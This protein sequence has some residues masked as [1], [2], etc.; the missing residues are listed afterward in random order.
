MSKDFLNKMEKESNKKLTEN[1]AIAYDTTMSSLLDAFSTLGA[2]RERSDQ[3]ILD[4]FYRAFAEDKKLAIKL[5]FYVRDIRGIGLGERRAFRVILSDLA[6]KY[7]HIIKDNIHNI[8]MYGRYDDLLCL[9]GTLAEKDALNFIDRQ[10]AED[11]MSQ[12]P[13]LL[14]KW[15]PSESSAN[16]NTR[17]NA[18]IIAK[19]I[20]LTPTAYRKT[21]SSLR[22]KIRIVETLLSQNRLDEVDF[23]ILPS[24]AS[25]RYKNT[26]IK[27][28]PERYMEYLIDLANGK[29]N[30]N[31]STLN[32]VD[33][34]KKILT[35]RKQD[36]YTSI[37]YDA[38]WNA[39]PNYFEGLDETGICVVDTSGSMMCNEGYPLY[40]AVSLGIYCADKCKGAF[41]NKFITFSDNPKIQTVKGHNI[42]EKVQNLHNSEWGMSTNI[43]K[44]FDLILDTA[45]KNNS[46]QEDIPNKLYLITDMEWNMAQRGNTDSATLMAIIE[47]KFK[48]AG[49]SMPQLVY[50]NVNARN[51][52]FHNTV[53]E[54]GY[55][56]VSG[57]SAGTFKAI[58]QGTELVEEVN[59]EGEVTV[60]EKLDPVLM[61]LNTL[62]NERYDAIVI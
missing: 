45:I 26:F 20:N 17:K 42:V 61:M 53:D 10:L 4:T 36:M 21:I 12:T 28:Q 13:S 15:L 30:I 38:S 57:Y 7:P 11:R 27:K 56:M 32:P 9:I 5:L 49:Y 48:L 3:D 23:N 58:I 22:E 50:W 2:M 35:E 33:I 46:P 62:N 37:L 39:L 40:S 34:V 1:G 51:N 24:K 14:A 41:E 44:V 43:E 47:G 19:H 52:T 29:A 60:K 8:P 18:R 54:T 16:K 31:A 25:L 6:S 55:C 59:E